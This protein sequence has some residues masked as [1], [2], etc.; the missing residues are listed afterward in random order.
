MWI[1]TST[2][3]A[4]D[5]E[6]AFAII[7]EPVEQCGGRAYEVRA[8]FQDAAVKKYFRMETFSKQAKA[9]KFIAELVNELNG[10]VDDDEV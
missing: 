8:Y 10:E 1:K 3:D 9:R 7:Y 2:G 6:K 5:I 4:V